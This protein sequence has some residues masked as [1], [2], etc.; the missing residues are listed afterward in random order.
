M[1][2]P[3]KKQKGYLIFFNALSTKL[4]HGGQRGL[5]PPFLLFKKR[6]ITYK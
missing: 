2:D 3:V 1:V 5:I 6:G 4:T